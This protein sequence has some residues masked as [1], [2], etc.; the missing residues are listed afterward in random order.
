METVQMSIDG[1]IGKQNVVYLHNESLF[2]QKR[3]EVLIH[4]ATQMDPENTASERSQTKKA[5]YCMSHLY[6]ICR[7][8]KSTDTESRLAAVEGWGRGIQGVTANE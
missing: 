4:A 2:S 5:T 1:W 3:N 6:K 7:R 8:G